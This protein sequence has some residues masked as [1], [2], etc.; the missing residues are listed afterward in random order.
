MPAGFRYH[1]HPEQLAAFAPFRAAV[2][3]IL[4]L[5]R[6]HKAGH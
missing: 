1:P 5:S 6:L 2:D 4:P 3:S